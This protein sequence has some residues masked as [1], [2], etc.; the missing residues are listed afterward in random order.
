[1]L[2]KFRTKNDIVLSNGVF[3]NGGTVV[4]VDISES[5]F[6]FIAPDVILGR[7]QIVDDNDI[8]KPLKDTKSKKVKK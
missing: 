3:L 7:E 1:M 6:A 5:E 2:Y 8:E 4:E